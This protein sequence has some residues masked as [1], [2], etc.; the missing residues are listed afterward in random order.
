MISKLP[1]DKPIG[2]ENIVEFIVRYRN[3]TIMEFLTRYLNVLE[4]IR[5]KQG[6]ESILKEFLNSQCS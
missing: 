2:E 6:K 5:L 1:Q 4:R 3:N